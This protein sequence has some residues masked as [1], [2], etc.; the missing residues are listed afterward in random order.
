M[1]DFCLKKLH[2]LPGSA[3]SHFEQSIDDGIQVHIVLIRHA[4]LPVRGGYSC[5]SELRAGLEG[6]QSR[7]FTFLVPDVKGLLSFH[8]VSQPDKSLIE[9]CQRN[10][11]E[12]A[13][14]AYTTWRWGNTPYTST[15]LVSTLVQAVI[16]LLGITRV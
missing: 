3:S 12:R 1:A 11:Q 2:L 8:S 5:L 14:R 10:W 6:T 9:A 16:R 4:V 7:P 15:Y 13:H